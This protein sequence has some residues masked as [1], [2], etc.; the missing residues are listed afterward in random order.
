MLA[1]QSDFLNRIEP[2]V[3]SALFSWAG[4]APGSRFLYRIESNR[5]PKMCLTRAEGPPGVR[6]VRN[7]RMCFDQ[8]R[9]PA[10][11]TPGQKSQNLFFRV[12]NPKMCLT[13]AE[14]PHGVRQVENP[15]MVLTRAEGP[16]RVRQV[17]NPKMCFDQG[18]RP[19]RGTP[20]QKSQNVF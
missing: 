16:T 13:R 14:G 6:Q 3:S 7:P 19:T 17:K 8:G 10:R 2:A 11:G 15:K 9:R 4:V 1:H 20:G 5:I 18:R 12:K